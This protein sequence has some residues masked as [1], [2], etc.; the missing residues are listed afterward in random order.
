MKYSFKFFAA[1]S[2]GVSRSASVQNKSTFFDNVLKFENSHIE[3]EN[4]APNIFQAGSKD[5]LRKVFHA[6]DNLYNGNK[7]AFGRA[8]SF[9]RA[10]KNRQM[11]D[12]LKKYL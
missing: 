6:I 12:R 7:L 10:E 4:T 8:L 11:A 9:A 1:A 2:V 3:F 5:N